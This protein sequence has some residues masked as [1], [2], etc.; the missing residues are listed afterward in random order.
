MKIKV[1]STT[2]LLMKENEAHFLLLS[3]WHNIFMMFFKWLVLVFLM[4]A[5]CSFFY[6]G[7]ILA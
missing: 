5:K 6:Y 1:L 3:L 7:G 4:V 2:R